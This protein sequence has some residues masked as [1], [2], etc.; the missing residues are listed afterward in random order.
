MFYIQAGVNQSV[1]SFI[2]DVTNGITWLKGLTLKIVIIPENLYMQANKNLS[3]EEG[4]RFSVFCLQICLSIFLFS[5]ISG[6]ILKLLPT[7]M[8]P[9]SDYYQGKVFE[10]RIL[11]QPAFGDVKSGKSKVNRFTHKQ[12][13]AGS[14]QYVH[15][16]SENAT[17]S[18]KVIAIARNKES[19]PFDL[20]ISIIQVND[21]VPV[22]VTNT[23]LQ[24]WAG[25]RAAIK[26]TDL[27]E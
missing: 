5:R 21:E 1:D 18:I 16:G 7:D 15:D 24:M 3:V 27:S 19:V 8:V 23:G 2:F 13:E 17:D 12:L 22:I 26:N 10:Y 4:M 25:G 14:I 11:Q 9:F 6:K 20:R